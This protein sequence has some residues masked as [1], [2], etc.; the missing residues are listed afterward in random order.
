M[1][2]ALGLRPGRG[3]GRALR[4]VIDERRDDLAQ[5]AGA[6][7]GQ[8][9]R[10]RG[11]RRGRGTDRL[12]RDGRRRRR[13]GWRAC[14]PPS[15]DAEQARPAVP[16]AARAS[17]ASSA[18][19]TGR[20]RCPGRS[21][22]RP[23]RTGT[24]WCGARA[25][26]RRV[27]AVKLAECIAE[28]RSPARGLQHGDRA[29][30]RGRRRDRRRTRAR[31]R[32][33]SSAR[34]RPGC[35]VAERAAGKELLLEMGGNGPLVVLDDADL[36]AAVEATLTACFLNAGQSCTAGERILVHASGPRCVR[37]A[38]GRG[39]RRREI[40]LGDPFDDATTMGP[41]NN[42]RDR[43][44]DRAPRAE[45]ATAEPS[46]RGRRRAR[47]RARQRPLLRATVLDGVTEDMEVAREETFG[48]V[49]PITRDRERGRGDRDRRTRRPT[50]C[51]RPCSRG[52]SRRG[53]AVRRGR[54][55]RLGQRQRRHELLGVAPAL[56][57][58]GRL[59]ER[60][61]TGRRAVLD[62]AS[63]R[64]QDGSVLHVG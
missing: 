50:G 6:G 25:D 4:A 42:E 34:S 20:T 64:A 45:A 30:R 31:R 43:R 51:S 17:W 62:G 3:D 13:R 55:R 12:L 14:I 48:P 22:P 36:D 33:G 41:L 16:G 47:A 35:A 37:R 26:A 21:S 63:D 2:R 60:R 18:R 46:G 57:R 8:A 29:G 9:P 23:S 52:I 11:A 61:G 7:P 59:E 53:P 19:G 24:R 1:G 44:Q 39:R 38:P 40:R 54:P 49:V 32:W 56:R 10:R 28:A 27:C 5:D 58:A 15:V